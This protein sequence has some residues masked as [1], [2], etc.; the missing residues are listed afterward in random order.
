MNVISDHDL[1][2]AMNHMKKRITTSYNETTPAHITNP[3]TDHNSNNNNDHL[4]GT[5]S[6]LLHNYSP[7]KISLFLKFMQNFYS[8]VSDIPSEQLQCLLKTK[9]MTTTPTSPTKCLD[10]RQDQQDKEVINTSRR[11]TTTNSNEL[12]NNYLVDDTTGDQNHADLP[13]QLRTSEQQLQNMK[14]LKNLMK[15]YVEM[16]DS[17][18]KSQ[19]Q[20]Q[21]NEVNSSGLFTSTH[22][23][24]YA[25]KAF[26]LL[27]SE[28]G[29]NNLL[30]F[31]LHN[32][33]SGYPSIPIYNRNNYPSKQCRRRKARTVFSDH[34]LTGLEHRFETQHYLST[35]ERIELANRLNLSET[36]VKTW[37]QNRR[38]KHKKLKRCIPDTQLFT[39]NN[40]SSSKCPSSTGGDDEDDDDVGGDD[41]VE[42][43]E[44]DRCSSV[45]ENPNVTAAATKATT[46][47]PLSSPT[48]N[49]N[50]DTASN[51][52]NQE[53]I[54]NDND[55]NIN[56]DA[57][58]GQ[59]PQ[60]NTNNNNTAATAASIH[61]T[62][63][64][65]LD[66]PSKKYHSAFLS[67]VSLISSPSLT[68]IT[69][70]LPFSS[71]FPYNC[72]TSSA[73][74]NNTA[75]RSWTNFSS[76]LRMDDLIKNFLTYDMIDKGYLRSTLDYIN[77]NIS[78][79]NNAIP[80][81]NDQHYTAHN[82]SINNNTLLNDEYSLKK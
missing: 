80:L 57:E 74:N 40:N 14:I 82:L 72:Y 79:V 28:C 29:T 17:V 3:T 8:E 27:T 49:D 45:G 30:P 55:N 11:T 46:T 68:T 53:N 47:A 34:Q 20:Q 6:Q 71:S 60:V 41:G 56:I 75:P 48:I 32:P 77:N 18:L 37:F 73:S 4:M 19:Q 59:Y 44:D 69:S 7:E 66:D 33:A 67:T 15:D 23:M 62:G 16:K 38:M 36:Q 9:L 51:H 64:T 39:Q 50:T 2:Y 31:M 54:D 78:D 63:S 42:Q 22:D 24:K 58:A 25:Q 26:E 1:C 70:T 43:D 52:R 10:L 61:S 13:P 65:K 76:Q 5:M 81:Q 12:S 21:Q 35:P